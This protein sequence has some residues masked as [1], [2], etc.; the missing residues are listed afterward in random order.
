[1][2]DMC[3]NILVVACCIALVWFSPMNSNAMPVQSSGVNLQ[4]RNMVT[5]QTHQRV[6]LNQV[7]NL[8]DDAT[9]T[10]CSMAFERIE[11]KSKQKEDSLNKLAKEHISFLTNKLSFL[12]IVITVAFGVLAL[13]AVAVPVFTAIKFAEYKG[14]YQEVK[15]KVDES[16]SQMRSLELIVQKMQRESFCHLANSYYLRAKTEAEQYKIALLSGSAAPASRQ[17]MLRAYCADMLQGMSYSCNGN[18]LIQIYRILLTVMMV[19]VLI[20]TPNGRQDASAVAANQKLALDVSIAK[21]EAKISK[22]LIKERS[23]KLAIKILVDFLDTVKV[24]YRK[25]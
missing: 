23:A 3:H 13:V 6:T 2:I 7:K 19:G 12:S 17:S 8:I 11:L 25:N 22:P 4:Y 5:D 9:N 20:K 14:C 10:V 16:I 1:M 18:A 24:S 21:I 15:T